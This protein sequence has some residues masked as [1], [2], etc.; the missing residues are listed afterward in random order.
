[1]YLILT[2]ERT[3]K[4]LVT[5]IRGSFT[6]HKEITWNAVKGLPYLGAC[7][8]EALRMVPPAPGNFCRITPPEGGMID[9]NWVAGNVRDPFSEV[10]RS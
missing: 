5:E 8:S 3:Y 10:V 4:K 2:N 9:G 7:I 6:S 1:M